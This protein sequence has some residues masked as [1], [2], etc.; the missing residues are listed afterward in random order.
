M[1]QTQAQAA[2][3]ALGALQATQVQPPSI[4]PWQPGGPQMIVAVTLT[5]AIK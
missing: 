2:G 1:A 3:V 5:Y 4:C